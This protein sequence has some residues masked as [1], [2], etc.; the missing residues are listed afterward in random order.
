MLH[1]GDEHT[2]AVESSLLRRDSIQ[3]VGGA[4]DEDHDL[5]LLVDAQ[6]AADEIAGPLVRLRGKAGFVARPAVHAGVDVGERVHRL[7]HALQRRRAGRVVEV[8]PGHAGAAVNR[9]RQVDSGEMLAP[10]AGVRGA[11]F[12]DK[13]SANL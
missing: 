13:S 5:L 8:D 3:C 6:E 12:C 2:P 1:L 7:A 10:V 9:N 11:H 4:F